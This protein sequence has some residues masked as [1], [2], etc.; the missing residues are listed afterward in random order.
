MT[1]I[2]ISTLFS[3]L[4]TILVV[5]YLLLLPRKHWTTYIVGGLAVVFGIIA[6]CVSVTGL[7]LS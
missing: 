3:G 7:V 6:V 5:I 4:A 2:R 1:L